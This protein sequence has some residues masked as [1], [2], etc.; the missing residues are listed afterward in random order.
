MLQAIFVRCVK[1]IFCVAITV[2]RSKSHHQKSVIFLC[3]HNGRLE[4]EHEE[5]N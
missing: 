1:G 3:R 4:E 2:L 5:R